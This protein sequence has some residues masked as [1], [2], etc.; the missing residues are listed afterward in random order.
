[1][2]TVG[3][4][5]RGREVY[6]VQHN[7]TVLEAVRYMVEKGIGAVA[8]M[9]GERMVGIF[10]ERDLMK[11]VVL[12]QLDPSALPLHKVMTTNLVLAAPEESYV[13][14]LAKMQSHGIRHLA[15]VAQD[16]LVGMISVRD[17][18]SKDLKEKSAE[19]E[20]MN[21]YLYYTPPNAA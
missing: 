15:I 1:M 7:Q 8:V 9:E 19:L 16:R 12:R 6:S 11:R 20:L 10:S 21:A 4:L 14:A 3:D 18:L 2:N 17:L 5:V 13:A